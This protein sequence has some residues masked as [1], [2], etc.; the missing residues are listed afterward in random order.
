MQPFKQFVEAREVRDIAS[1][2]IVH[3]LQQ[4]NKPILSVKLALYCAEDCFQF[5]NEKTREP[6]RRCIAL[7]RKWLRDPESVKKQELR[8]F[9][10]AAA[11]NTAANNAWNAAVNAVYAAS[12][13]ATNDIYAYMNS[14][15]ASNVYIATYNTIRYAAESF[16]CASE[17]PY[18]SPEWNKI[19]AK[20]F[21]TYREKAKSLGTTRS[22]NPITMPFLNNIQ[23]DDNDLDNPE[24][25][26]DSILGSIMSMI[27][28]LYDQQ[29][30]GEEHFFYE[31]GNEFVFDL[32]NNVKLTADNLNDL[33]KKIY[34]NKYFLRRLKELYNANV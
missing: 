10:P 16:A 17:H 20:K 2:D 1:Y 13:R 26:N 12:G 11:D 34:R 31:K 6:A 15:Y 32:G 8:F 27:D 3:I 21:H 14:T 29:E 23:D 18:N 4:I 22:G 28:W 7:V 5:N 33:A 25:I 30:T 24:Y 19:F 9:E